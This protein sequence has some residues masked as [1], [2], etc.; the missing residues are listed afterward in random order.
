MT[1]PGFNGIMPEGRRAPWKF[2]PKLGQAISVTFGQPIPAESLTAAM[3]SYTPT[4]EAI[5]QGGTESVNAPAD[6]RRS[7]YRPLPWL[8]RVRD[9]SVSHLLR[10]EKVGL[11][12]DLEEGTIK[13]V[14]AVRSAVTAVIQNEVEALGRMVSGNMLGKS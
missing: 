2:M 14:Q 12:D 6:A 9:T 3:E 7:A 13:R 1:I 4:P 8:T 5:A 11:K 10:G